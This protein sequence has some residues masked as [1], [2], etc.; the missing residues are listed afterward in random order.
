MPN[1]SWIAISHKVFD[2]KRAES[3]RLT[4]SG[5]HGLVTASVILAKA[6]VYDNQN[7]L[8]SQVYGAEARG[9]ST[10]SETIIRKGNIFFPKLV[11]P[12]F[13]IALTHE[14]LT[15]FRTDVIKQGLIVYDSLLIPEEQPSDVG[16]Y[17]IGLPMW[18]ELM[19][20]LN[21]GMAV[22]IVALGAL[23]GF[24]G[25]VKKES[26]EKAVHENFRAEFRPNNQKALEIGYKLASEV[27]NG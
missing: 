7:V 23:V 20:Q 26:L 27:M 2:G 14:G 12:D 19:K 15:K 17:V 11:A 3:F 21:T 18:S 1:P 25:V 10:K 6:G 5:G 13:L 24:T 8:Q 4:G 16:P 9:G 22:N